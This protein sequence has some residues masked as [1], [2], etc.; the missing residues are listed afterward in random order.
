MSA[1][2]Q[3]QTAQ[4]PEG[5]PNHLAGHVALDDGSRVLIRPILPGDTA[6]LKRALAGADPETLLHRFFTAAPHLGEKEIHYLAE[7]DYE[8]RL[9]LVAL[10]D[11]GH[12]VGIARHEGLSDPKTAEV[13]VVVDPQWRRRGLAGHLLS[14]LEGPA[15]R[16]GIERFVAVY[17]P[18]NRAVAGL[19]HQLGYS[20]PRLEDGLTRV[21]KGIG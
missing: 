11:E 5:Y 15:R 17:L 9:A 14:R 13:A 1:R 6:E 10:D 20:E 19:F 7:V 21:E 18:E 8:R 16:H 2:D 3:P 4:V 12:G